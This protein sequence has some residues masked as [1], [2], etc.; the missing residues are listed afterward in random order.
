MDDR[1]RQ[2]LADKGDN[3]I[4][5]FFWQHGEE[6]AL[7]REEMARIHE[8]GVGSVCIEARPHP[9]FGGPLWWR[10]MDIIMDEA[11]HRD[12]K[13]WLLDDA[14][15]PTGFAN[16]WIRDRVP[17]KCRKYL[18]EKHVDIAGPMKNGSVIV[19]AWLNKFDWM[20]AQEKLK[21][22]DSLLAVV[23]VRRGDKAEEIDDSLLDL[24]SKVRDGVL[25]WDVPEGPWRVFI[26]ILT[27]NWGGDPDYINIIDRDS[28]RV[29]LD[30]VY[31]PHFARYGKDF[32][33]T[34]AG[35]FSDEPS[36]G[37]TRGFNFDESIGRKKM[38]LPWCEELGR[39]L[40]ME[41]GEGFE[42]FL[43]CLWYDN[44]KQSSSVRF[45]YMDLV[46]QL[47]DRNFASQIGEWCSS[48]NVEYI[49]HVIEDQNVHARLGC[50]SGHYFRALNGQHMSGIDIIGQQVLPRYECLNRDPL[51]A[52]PLP[53]DEF[54]QFGLAKMGSS[55]GHIDPKKKGRTLCEIFG[56]SGWATGVKLMKWLID[57]S[58]VRG[59]NYFVPHAFSAKEFPDPDC[60]PHFYA[61]GRNP[62]F[63]YFG[64]LMR[65][66]NRLCNLLNGGLHIAPAAVLYHAEAEWSGRY[67]YFQKPAHWLTRS[68][69]DHDILPSDVFSNMA[70][71]N[72]RLQEDKLVVNGES[73]RCLVVPFS[74]HITEAVAE[75]IGSAAKSGFMAIFVDG[76]P[77]GICGIQDQNRVEELLK[78]LESS[79]VSTL[80]DLPGILRARGVFEIELSSDEPYLRY[81]HYRRE[82]AD[83]YMF[84]NEHPYDSLDTV[85][86]I[87][88]GGTAYL[89]D[90]FENRLAPLTAA[91]DGRTNGDLLTKLP[92]KLSAYESAVVVFGV[93]DTG[94]CNEL[95]PVATGYASR[96][97][98]NHEEQS[99]EYII[100]EV[101]GKWQ[102]S[103]A[104]ASEY[105][106]F[107]YE[108]ELDKLGDLSTPGHFP[109]FSGTFRYETEFILD[110]KAGFGLPVEESGNAAVMDLGEVYEAAEVWVN[111]KPGG[112]RIC[113]P[114][115]FNITDMLKP[116]INTLRIDVTNTLIRE[117]QDPMS[118]NM[119]IEPTGLFGPVRISFIK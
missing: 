21:M 23:A 6:E 42:R 37:N 98:Q 94:L 10:D 20:F 102:L 27:E 83:I 33:G 65:Y 7:L 101:N 31:E 22:K 74:E 45:K 3:Y 92:L 103:M 51:P 30:A 78:G 99:L 25:Y 8:C 117:V 96:F 109:K 112:V 66:T 82:K 80:E 59:I 100:P 76:L 88:I 79:T 116:G 89:Y 49:G 34:F 108:M 106:D 17:E 26:L 35:F 41:L 63:R 36:F 38:V 104:T 47:Y 97:S 84:F 13:V 48:H 58:L 119:L 9:D 50:G 28:V 72:A 5:P 85:V 93:I 32:G 69:I 53:D 60:P 77:T 68:Q 81:Y 40:E 70:A 18:M 114:Y 67:M 55:L 71:Y 14:H 16:G 118:I 43:P 19:N 64:H 24:T 95:H 61:R 29:L 113:P 110:S 1:L 46:T 54:S 57:H 39:S 11:R 44:E 4:L 73:Y 90:A 87:P 107:T 91:T 115:R 86:S 105:P 15:F 62:Q 75:F 56:A 2:V 12:M 111:G 52:G